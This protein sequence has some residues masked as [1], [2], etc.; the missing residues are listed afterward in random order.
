MNKLFNIIKYAIITLTGKDDTELPTAQVSYLGKTKVVELVLPYGLYSNPKEQSLAL[1]FSVNGQEDNIS[2]I[3]HNPYNRFKNL[4][5]GEVAV[6]NPNTLTK[7]YFKEDGTIEIFT[8]KTLN[9]NA[10]NINLGSGGKAIA[11]KDDE[12]VGQVVIPAGSSAGTY[13]ITNGK[14]NVGSTKHTCN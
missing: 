11:R 9:I 10:T 1:L 3:P 7:I 6:G 14:I 5:T 13:N 4:K 8:D 2:A 12:V